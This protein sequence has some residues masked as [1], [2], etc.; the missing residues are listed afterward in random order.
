MLTPT[1]LRV[2]TKHAVKRLM[3]CSLRL[4][5]TIVE[6]TGLS[7]QGQY[8]KLTQNQ[9]LS[10]TIKEIV[11]VAED[12]KQREM[13]CLPLRKLPGWLMT[14]YPNKVK[15]EIRDTV[16]AYQNECDDA[17][18]DYWTKG[19]AN[20][21]QSGL[22]LP[23]FSNPAE[24]ARAWALEYEARQVAEQQLQLAAPK[25]A[26]HDQVTQDADILID[27][28]QA[29][30]LLKRRCGQTFTRATFLEF[31]RRHGVIKKPN[32]YAGITKNKLAPCKNYIG[33]WFESD[34][35]PMGITEWKLRPMAISGIIKLIEQERTSTA[36]VAGYLK[37][38]MLQA[39][40]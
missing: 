12:G 24:A 14:I 2:M 31:L 19:Q 18:W 3:P 15:P 22:S 35:T 32:L 27:L 26:F 38:P 1:L 16:I 36:M 6:G 5:L 20:R 9:R 8:E 40:Q 34:I 7:W 11:M 23:D 10:S 4:V 28:D 39:A 37:Q 25:V 29:F 13:V 21:R 17:L 33:S 30:S